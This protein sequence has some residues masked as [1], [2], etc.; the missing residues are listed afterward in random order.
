M[1]DEV[2]AEDPCMR[3]RGADEL[4]YYSEEIKKRVGVFKHG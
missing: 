4:R 1:R 3:P 2:V